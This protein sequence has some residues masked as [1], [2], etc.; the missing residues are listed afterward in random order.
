[1][2]TV[3]QA[4]D[5]IL[6]TVEPAPTELVGLSEA[7]GLALAEDVVCAN[8]SPPFDKSLMDGYAVRYSD[9]GSVRTQLVVREELT[10]GNVAA[11]PVNAGE[12]IRI[13]TGAPIPEGADTV[14]RSEDTEFDESQAKVTITALPVGPGTN[15]MRR[16]ASMRSGDRILKAG[17]AL[18]PQDLGTLAELG[19]HRVSTRRAPTVSVLATGDELVP[20]DQSPGPGRIRNS[21]ETMLTAQTRRAGGVPVALGIAS[22]DRDHLASRIAEGLRSRVL[23]L[24]GGVSAGTRDLV[25]SELQRAGVRQVFH[26]V[27]LKPGKPL[28]FGVR[29]GSETLS[30]TYV[31]GLPGNPVSSLVCVELFVRSAIRR[32]MGISPAEPQVRSA[33]LAQDHLVRGDRP[34]YHPA[35]LDHEASEVCV[36][37][38]TWQGSADLRA[39]VDANAMAVFPPGNHTW[40]CGDTVP[41]IEW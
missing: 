24:S 33:R 8:D 18:R 35:R 27:H 40:R 15:I 4:L 25:P 19:L 41:V 34:T 32:M 5:S 29:Q 1:M 3:E 23:I 36:T 13:M 16:A 10:A 17:R 20:I 31:F 11:N 38:V 14:I 12:A 6:D 39:T 2:L 26:K 22:D 7:A 37:P 30:L 21:N 28:W 9:V